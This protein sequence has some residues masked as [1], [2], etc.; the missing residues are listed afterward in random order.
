MRKRN[1]IFLGLT[2]LVIGTAIA[3][4]GGM[5]LIQADASSYGQITTSLRAMLGVGIAVILSGFGVM[6]LFGI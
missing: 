5:S 4:F 2:L 1:F 6:L 3:G